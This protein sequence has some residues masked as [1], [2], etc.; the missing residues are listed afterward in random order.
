[1]ST[2]SKPKTNSGRFTLIELLVVIAIIAILAAMLMPALS[3]A[4]EKAKSNNCLN[5]IKQC[6]LAAVQYEADFKFF[7]ATF[8]YPGRYR[9]WSRE[10]AENNYLPDKD[11]K[12][13]VDLVLTVIGHIQQIPIFALKL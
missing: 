13:I 9:A 6:A 5:N 2:M 8:Y 3:Q 1:M 10:L 11:S 12:N 7:A 4:R